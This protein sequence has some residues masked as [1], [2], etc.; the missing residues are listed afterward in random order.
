[1]IIKQITSYVA[2]YTN[3]CVKVFDSSG[4]ILFKFGVSDGEGKMLYPRGLV[5]CGEIILICN[6]GFFDHFIHKYQLN[7]A[8]DSKYGK[9]NVGFNAPCGLAC[10][11]SN[12]DI[13]ICDCFN[14]TRI[15]IL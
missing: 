12:G 15:Q 1:M 7:G 8:F 9:G 5:I 11:E 4:K 2:D 13:Y 14:N 3:H 10:D 6:N